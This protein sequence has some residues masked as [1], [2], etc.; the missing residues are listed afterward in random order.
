M[1]KGGI[2]LHWFFVIVAIQIA[3]FF[4]DVFIVEDDVS[5]GF[6]YCL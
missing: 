2:G 6:L 1:M 5:I 4:L 3:I